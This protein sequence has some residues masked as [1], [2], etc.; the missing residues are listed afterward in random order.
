MDYIDFLNF[1]KVSAEYTGNWDK[2]GMF[3]L[4]K[5]EIPWDPYEMSVSYF[6]AIQVRVSSVKYARFFLLW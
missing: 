1:R 3:D 4:P 5:K 2:F 6:L